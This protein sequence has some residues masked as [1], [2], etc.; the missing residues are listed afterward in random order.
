MTTDERI[1]ELREKVLRVAEGKANPKDVEAEIRREIRASRGNVEMLIE[2]RMNLGQ[3]FKWTKDWAKMREQH[4]KVLKLDPASVYAMLQMAFS[5]SCRRSPKKERE[6]FLL[7]YQTAVANG[8]HHYQLSALNLL[9]M[10]D[11][12]DSKSLVNWLDSICRIL[13]CAPRDRFLSVGITDLLAA[14]GKAEAALPLVECL[15]KHVID[16]EYPQ[17]YLRKAFLS[18]VKIHR[19]LGQTDEEIRHLLEGFR[20]VDAGEDRDKGFD[21]SIAWALDPDTP[22]YSG[23]DPR[24]TVWESE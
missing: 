12:E 9:A 14:K 6:W 16:R 22:Q 2:H 8:D 4:R 10:C 15:I 17:T 23:F 3:L 5:Y 13:E 7:A 20:P 1:C 19:L 24:D 11:I 18:F 21:E